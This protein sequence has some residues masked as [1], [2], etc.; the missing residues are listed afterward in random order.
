MV[1]S[2]F[3]LEP[4]DPAGKPSLRG[5]PT[6]RLTFGGNGDPARRFFFV[7]PFGRP[8]RRLSG[9]AVRAQSRR[10]TG[11]IS[12]AACLLLR[13]VARYRLGLVLVRQRRIEYMV[14]V[15][16]AGRL[17]GIIHGGKNRMEKTEEKIRRL[18]S[19]RC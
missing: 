4:T 17:H 19:C 6:G 3:T 5:L 10:C 13:V 14:V 9:G 2:R 15:A 11:P 12:R 16:M 7:L 18:W 8:G 1:L